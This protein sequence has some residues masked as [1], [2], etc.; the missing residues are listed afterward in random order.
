M[1]LSNVNRRR[2]RQPRLWPAPRQTANSVMLSGYVAG[3]VNKP[4]SPYRVVCFGDEG[5]VIE[6]RTTYNRYRVSA[7]QI[8]G[9]E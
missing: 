8:S 5:V 9:R 2:R 7:E 3:V 1:S 6:H 4:D